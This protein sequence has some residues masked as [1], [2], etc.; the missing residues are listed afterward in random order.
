M[1]GVV[2]LVVP[3]GT[4]HETSLVEILKAWPCLDDPGRA[5]LLAVARGLA[6]G[7]ATRKR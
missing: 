4:P 7:K 1:G 2:P 3:S 6:S 5:D